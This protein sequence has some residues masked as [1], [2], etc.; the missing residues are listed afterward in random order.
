VELQ[1]ILISL[2]DPN[3]YRGSLISG[4]GAG[5]GFIR[6]ISIMGDYFTL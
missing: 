1:H 3:D 5:A 6:Y 2:C 4:A